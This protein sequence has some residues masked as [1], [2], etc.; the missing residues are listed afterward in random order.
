MLVDLGFIRLA[1]VNVALCLIL[2]VT[3]K[4]KFKLFLFLQRTLR[5]EGF[6]NVGSF[7]LCSG[8]VVVFGKHRRASLVPFSWRY[9][10]SQ[11]CLSH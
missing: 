11:L 5:F 8:N 10:S 3:V 7:S 9:W 1:L 2:C 4:E 6:C